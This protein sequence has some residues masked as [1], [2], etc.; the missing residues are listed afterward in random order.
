MPV[1]A[2]YGI[3]YVSDWIMGSIICD[4]HYFVSGVCTA[5]SFLHLMCIAIDRYLSVTRIQYSRNKSLTH[6]KTMISFSWT[7]AILVTC[8]PGLGFRD[9]QI[10]MDRI[11]KNLCIPSDRN[12][13]AKIAVL[14]QYLIPICVIAPLYY[15]VYKKSIEFKNKTKPKE[16]NEFQRYKPLD[17]SDKIM[18]RELRVARTLAIITIVH[19]LC[20]LPFNILLFTT[21]MNAID[22]KSMTGFLSVI[23]LVFFNSTLNPILYG[24]LNSDFRIAFKRL[25]NMSYN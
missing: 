9:N 4:I 16:T 2:Y 19:M 11:R 17:K 7:F 5:S 25:M 23:W 6:I 13:L 20:L 15:G 1:T 24:L 12:D 22:H 18:R 3:V 8:W 14:M 21:D 10:F